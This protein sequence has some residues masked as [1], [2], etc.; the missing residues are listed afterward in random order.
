MRKIFVFLFVCSALLQAAAQNVGIGTNTPAAKLQVAGN[1]TI[2]SG[3]RVNASNVRVPFLVE[4]SQV[5]HFIDQNV[6][7]YNLSNGSFAPAWQTFTAGMT[8]TLVQ[9]DLYAM[10]GTPTPR[11]LSIYAGAGTQG[12]LLQSVA[13][14]STS[15]LSWKNVTGFSVPLVEG[16]IYTIHIDKELYWGY[17]NNDVYSGG[18]SSRGNSFDYNFRTI[19][20]NVNDQYLRIG[21]NGNLGVGVSLP[22]EKL[23]VR[24]NVKVS[25]N[26]STQG[27][28]TTQGNLTIVGGITTFGNLEI[29]GYITQTD[30]T[31]LFLVYGWQNYGETYGNALYAK[32]KQRVVRLSGLVKNGAN[33]IIAQ[34]PSGFRPATDLIFTV[35]SGTGFARL[36][37]KANGNVQLMGSYSNLYVSLDGITFRSY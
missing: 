25:G 16:Q 32:D 30:A 18:V 2:D 14:G 10:Y 15:N 19:M 8:G 20:D 11:V 9:V 5:N 22:T 26:L 13:I 31:D 37:V 34:L 23:D 29:N 36:D 21:D 6:T 24:G 12:A 4:G 35:V 28:L 33:P 27:D 1:V 3:L 17:S 7:Q